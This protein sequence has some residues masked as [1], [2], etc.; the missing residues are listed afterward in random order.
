MSTPNREIRPAEIRA[1]K[2]NRR[3]DVGPFANY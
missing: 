2:H 3:V 1:T